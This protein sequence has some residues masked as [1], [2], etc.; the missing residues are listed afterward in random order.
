MVAIRAP[1][2]LLGDLASGIEFRHALVLEQRPRKNA[3]I[4]S[5][6]VAAPGESGRWF[7]TKIIKLHN[8][9]VLPTSTLHRSLY[10]GLGLTVRSCSREIHATHTGEH[11]HSKGLSSTENGRDVETL[12]S[13]T[14]W[15]KSPRRRAVM[16]VQLRCTKCAQRSSRLFTRE[17]AAVSI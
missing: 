11:V 12:L 10:T 16:N 8:L 5:V 1:T 13:R 9:P 4:Q 2:S 15:E 6:S 3:R 17:G 7:D 14:H